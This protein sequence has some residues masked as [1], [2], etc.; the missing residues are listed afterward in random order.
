[1]AE[2]FERQPSEYYLARLH[3]Q[4]DAFEDAAATVSA[5]IA[6]VPPGNR[7]H[8]I[9]QATHPD[10]AAR[11]QLAQRCGLRPFQEKEGFWWT[12]DGTGA[13]D[14]GMNPAGLTARPL[15]DSDHQQFCDVIRRSVVGIQDRVDQISLRAQ[16]G[17][18][19]AADLLGHYAMGSDASL[20]QLGL[21][22]AGA[23][24]GFVGLAAADDDREGII[25][26]IGVLPEHRGHGHGSGLLGIAKATAVARSWRG[27]LSLVDV[28]N[29]PMVQTMTRS[30]FS[31]N[32]R[33][34][35]K[36]HYLHET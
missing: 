36:W 9:V 14:P 11:I 18:H 7:V 31:P 33:P 17:S 23:T 29:Q 3:W 27:L 6:D 30:G 26:H 28:V 32:S 22:T 2:V 8:L 25:V 19:W 35:H 5:A 12:A 20:W 15:T 1:M 21:D 13:A 10:A 16:G 34:W 24:I 4:T